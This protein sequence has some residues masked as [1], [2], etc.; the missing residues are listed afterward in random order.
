MANATKN[1]PEEQS[2]E[3]AVWGYVGT[4]VLWISLLL[5]GIAFE[6]L[7]LSAN[8]LTGV[9]PGETGTLRAQ[10]AELT[11]DLGAVKN[12]RDA[13]KLTENALRVEIDKLKRQ[14]AAATA[15]PTTAPT[16]TSTP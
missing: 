2:I 12:E 4:G 10:V 8:I 6:R 9:L 1:T 7:G 15:Q 14:V 16:P 11:R 13:N 3:K 5:T